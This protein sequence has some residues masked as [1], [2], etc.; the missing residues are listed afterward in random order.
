MRP[1]RVH[2]RAHARQLVGAAEASEQRGREGRVVGSG[3][4]R[5][6]EGRRG[7]G[8]V[9]VGDGEGVG[10]VGGRRHLRVVHVSVVR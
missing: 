7:R 2:A 4:W 5:Q 10:A 3:E 9:A 8:G 1:R 6:R